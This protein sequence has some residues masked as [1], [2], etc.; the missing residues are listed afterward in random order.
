M[1]KG[2][3]IVTTDGLTPREDSQ[4]ARLLSK[5][6]GG[7]IST[8]VF[9]QLARITPIAIVEVV[10]LR[11]SNEALET[12]LIPR[13]KD[14]PIWHGMYHTPGT[15]LR[16]SDY[17]RA[18]QNPLKGAFERIEREVN[19][20]LSPP[21]YAGLLLRLSERGPD[22]SQ[23]FIAQLLGGATLQ[24]EHLWYPVAQLAGYSNFIQAQLGHVM[25]A[26]DAYRKMG[27]NLR[28]YYS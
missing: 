15:T 25:L 1:Q 7:R 6:R 16:A 23:I 19:N 13:P 10:I 8:P 18:D 4:L 22:V 17:K 28:T 11:D 2:P 27:D 24:P 5:W 20:E 21:T 12:L 9:T 26:T 14:D 3:E